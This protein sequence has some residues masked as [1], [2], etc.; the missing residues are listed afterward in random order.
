MEGKKKTVCSLIVLLAVIGTTF[1]LG[2]GFVA[3]FSLLFLLVVVTFIVLL[4][5]NIRNK[6]LYLILVIAVLLHLLS[7][8]FIHYTEFRP[9]GGGAD[10]EGYNNNAVEV[11]KRFSKGNFSLEGLYTNHY[12]AV[13]VGIIYL[14][15]GP[16]TISVQLFLVWLAMVS[17]LLSYFLVIELGGS[18]KSAFLA[19]L[20]TS[21]YPS[22][23]YFGSL[24]LKDTLVVPLA[25]VGLLLSLKIMKNF[26]GLNFLM[27]FIVLA[28]LIHFRFY[29][30]LALLFSF[31]IC[32]FIIS[33]KRIW[34]RIIYGLAIIFILGFS[35]QLVGFGYYGT[36]SFKGFLNKSTIKQYREIVY[37]PSPD[38]KTK[39]NKNTGVGSS[40]VVPTGFDSPFTFTKGYLTSFIYSFFGPFPWQLRYKRHLFFLADTVPWYLIWIIALS[41]I[42][43]V[44]KEKGFFPFVQLHKLSL[45]FLLFS[46]MAFGALSLFINNFGIIGRVRM[47]IFI[48]LL[49][50]I[51][52][53]FKFD[54]FNKIKNSL[55]WLK[56]I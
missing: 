28:G 14:I 23:L 56:D 13:F 3:G 26:S 46:V 39:D 47:P 9:V 1:F 16:E 30:G 20:I 49:C 34:E 19:G 21:F 37:A 8:L 10:Y 40:F 27:F 45:F 24:L 6:E 51:L 54:Y 12:F 33:S 48:A 25:L 18:E 31:I 42:F 2:K 22:Y 11:A 41:G 29:I 55:S 36:E 52:L 5:L 17:V 38:F 7:V 50:V 44:I 15:T 35:P 43:R 32:W 4:K 53:S